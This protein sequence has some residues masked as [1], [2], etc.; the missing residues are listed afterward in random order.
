MNH[1]LDAPPNLQR[2]RPP[3]LERYSSAIRCRRVRQ[4]VLPRRSRPEL[5]RIGNPS[6]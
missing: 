3:L 2:V 6:R 4:A 5:S 1:P